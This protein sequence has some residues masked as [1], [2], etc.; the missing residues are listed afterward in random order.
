MKVV[1]IITGLTDGGAE[2]V[3]FR[4][5]KNAQECQ[6]HVVS[7]ADDG[8]YGPMLRAIG[9]NVTTL[10]MSP[11]NPS[12]LAFIRLVR[13]LR[14]EE[15]DVV[16]TWMYHAD[17]FGGLAAQVAGIRSVVWGIHHTTLEPGKSKK[18]TILI[19]KLLAKLSW[20]LPAKIVVCAQRAIEVHEALGYDRSKMCFIPNG[21]DLAV[22]KPGLDPQGEMKA[23]LVPDKRIPLIGTVGRFDPLKDHANL[24]DALVILRDRGSAFRC[25]LVGKGLD[26]SNSQILEWIALRGLADHVQLLGLRND[27]PNIMNALD[28][29][30]L[31]S[32]AEAFPNVVA[33]AMACGTPC[34]V[35]DVGDAAD[36]VGDTGWVV[37]PRDASALAKT[38]VFALQDVM[39]TEQSSDRRSRARSRIEANFNIERM[40]SSYMAVWYESIES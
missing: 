30:V 40:V 17:L 21:Y 7:L 1:H 39:I 35:T 27:I 18:I 32:S 24:L 33:E 14:C 29:H 15:F 23:T 31:S 11:S 20:W 8:K 19:A 38:I 4:L 37:Q 3:L 34:V 12:L 22:F 10:N 5:C 6:H 36:I 13:L 2:A 16:Q 26:S 9:V 25:V 28:L